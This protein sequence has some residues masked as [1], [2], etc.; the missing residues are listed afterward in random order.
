MFSGEIS[1][2]SGKGG[3]ARRLSEETMMNIGDRVTLR[4]SINRADDVDQF[5]C[6]NKGDGESE[7][8]DFFF[9]FLH[10]SPL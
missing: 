2:G 4:M 7:Q 1:G 10:F 5:L 3:S 9:S 6:K 8:R